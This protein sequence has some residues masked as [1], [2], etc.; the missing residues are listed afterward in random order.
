MVTHEMMETAMQEH[1]REAGRLHREREA[2]TPAR[3]R[4][5][6]PPRGAPS[7]PTSQHPISSLLARLSSLASLL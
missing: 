3:R 2:R 5:D 1:M 6:A 7:Q 4:R